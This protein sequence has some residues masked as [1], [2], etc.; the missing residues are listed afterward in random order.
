MKR[1]IIELSDAISVF[2]NGMQ[3]LTE[4]VY[5]T[6]RLSAV[7]VTLESLGAPYFEKVLA[8]CSMDGVKS[9]M[10]LEKENRLPFGMIRSEIVNNGLG[11]LFA[12]TEGKEGGWKYV[13]DLNDDDNGVS[14]IKNVDMFSPYRETPPRELFVNDEMESRFVV[15]TPTSG[16]NKNFD[17]IAVIEFGYDLQNKSGLIYYYN[18]RTIP[19]T[20]ANYL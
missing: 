9:F 4:E 20:E 3:T 13:H 1:K 16:K 2:Q 6:G 12:E 14:Y 10:L 19:E 17:G 7:N 5:I 18:F 15:Y 8:S 11:F